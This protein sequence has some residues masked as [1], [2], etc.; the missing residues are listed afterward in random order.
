MW[1]PGRRESSRVHTHADKTYREDTSAPARRRVR[2]ATGLDWAGLRTLSRPTMQLIYPAH[3]PAAAPG[4]VGI[5]GSIKVTP[6]SM[7]AVC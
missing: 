5:S 1:A 7:P 6:L 3:H 2:R 4:P